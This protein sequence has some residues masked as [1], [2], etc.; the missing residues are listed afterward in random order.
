MLL[1][2]HVYVTLSAQFFWRMKSFFRVVFPFTLFLFALIGV[3]SLRV[4]S[5]LAAVDGGTT[6]NILLKDTNLNGKIDRVEVSVA[7]PSGDTWTVNGAVPNG[8]SVTQHH[9]LEDDVVSISSVSISGSATANPVTLLL[10][11]NESDPALTQT[12]DGISEQGAIELIYTQVGGGAGCTNCVK[13]SDEEL[14]SI[15]TGDIDG[16]D[17]EIDHAAPLILGMIYEDSYGAGPDLD[18]PDG[19]VD[20]FYV[21]FTESLSAVSTM[22]AANF[23][24]TSVGDFTGAVV[25]TAPEDL[26]GGG[27]T[28]V[29]N[30]GTV[31][32]VKDTKDDSGT[33]AI[34]LTGVFSLQDS[35]GNTYSTPSSLEAIGG[36]FFDGAFPQIKTATYLDTDNDGKIDSLTLDYTESVTGNSVLS[37]N[38][39]LFTNVGDFTDAAFGGST[40]D[41]IT[42]TTTTTTI[43]LGTEATVV[44]TNEGSGVIAISS[45]NAFYLEGIS[46]ANN[47]A[48]QAQGAVSFVDGASPVLMSSTPAAGA[49]GVTRSGTMTLNFSEPVT[50]VS[51][52]YTLLPTASLVTAPT[53]GSTASYTL[54]GTKSAGTNTLTVTGATDDTGHVL[55]PANTIYPGNAFTFTVASGGGP[56]ITD[57]VYRITATSPNG[58]EAWVAGDVYDILWSSESINGSAMVDANIYYSIDSGESWTLIAEDQLNNGSYS[59]ATP[60]SL[61]SSTVRVRVAGTDLVNEITSDSSD[62]DFSVAPSGTELPPI[63]NPTGAVDISEVVYGDYIRGV[64][65]PDVY[66]V[67]HAADGTL[68]RRPFINEQIFFTWQPNFKNVRY[69]TDESLPSMRV[70]IPVLP[71]SGT[72]LLKIQSLDNQLFSIFNV[73]QLRRIV[74]TAVAAA[75]Y[76]PAWTQYIL[77]VPP[78]LYP[79]FEKGEDIEGAEATIDPSTLRENSDLILHE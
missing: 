17:T 69:V 36:A 11:L 6:S 51:F 20:R 28:F 27:S 68:L 23:L 25:G 63:T 54:V 64:T 29:L 13:D 60:P 65:F 37:A 30:L 75:V 19:K 2:E 5:V 41:L 49:S 56:E 12:T 4:S 48:L 50:F 24:L 7:N 26:A 34:S 33:L 9:N 47:G 46:S 31:S 8:F 1:S 53:S 73:N 71:K 38:D 59:W 44:D 18:R 76:G 74:S 21:V 62:A 61:N 58:G 77:V 15:T 72:V 70:G 32:T 10:N 42:G 3:F 39:L 57:P 40:T 22:T 52:A 14:N 35:E 66:Y 45:Q 43:T 67:D 55:N 78:T 79:Y 16:R